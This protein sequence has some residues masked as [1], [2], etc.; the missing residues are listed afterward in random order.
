MS[1]FI[2]FRATLSKDGAYNAYIRTW[3]AT[4][5]MTRLERTWKSKSDSRLSSISTNRWSCPSTS[6]GARLEHSWSRQKK[7][8]PCIRK[9]MPEKTTPILSAQNQWLCTKVKCFLARQESPF[10]GTVR[11]KLIRHY[12]LL[13][14]YRSTWEL[15]SAEHSGGD[16]LDTSTRR[17][18]L[19]IEV[20][21]RLMMTYICMICY[22]I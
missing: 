18:P 19:M 2:Y 7:K 14:K 22:Q 8:Y 21:N 6:T 16:G 13:W 12:I 3:N 20:V 4:A 1:N 5:V 9:E 11:Q 15:S 17:Y 10:A